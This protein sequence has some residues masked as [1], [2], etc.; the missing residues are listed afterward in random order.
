MSGATWPSDP[1]HVTVRFPFGDEVLEGVVR[2]S[3]LA[4]TISGVDVVLRVAVDGDLY[5]TTRA[6]AEPIPDQY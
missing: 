2:D 4:P 5:R 6:E 1:T 3:F